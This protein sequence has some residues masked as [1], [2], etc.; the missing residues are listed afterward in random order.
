[1]KKIIQIIDLHV[2]AT[3][4]S[5]IFSRLG[6][7]RG[8]RLIIYTAEVGTRYI[9]GHLRSFLVLSPSHEE[10]DSVRCIP[11]KKFRFVIIMAPELRRQGGVFLGKAFGVWRC[12]RRWPFYLGRLLWNYFGPEILM[13]KG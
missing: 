7:G 2:M 13:A 8:G 5:K 11:H 9:E 3:S 1:M 4:L 12:Q 10:V 6:A